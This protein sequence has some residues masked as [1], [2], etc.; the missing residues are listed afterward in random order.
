MGLEGQVAAALIGTLLVG[1]N[2]AQDPQI[3]LKVTPLSQRGFAPYHA[4]HTTRKIAGAAV[5]ESIFYYRIRRSIVVEN[6]KDGK[7][8]DAFICSP[9]FRL[10]YLVNNGEEG[11][12]DMSPDPK[13]ACSQ[14]DFKKP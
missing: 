8:V 2:P 14:N 4:E 9:G 10:S 7:V 11:F 5:S 3:F 12:E 6:A 1:T 13:P